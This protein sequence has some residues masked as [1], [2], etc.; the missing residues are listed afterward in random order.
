M[1]KQNKIFLFA[2]AVFLEILISCTKLETLNNI[3]DPSSTNY[4]ATTTSFSRGTNGWNFIATNISVSNLKPYSNK[5]TTNIISFSQ[6]TQ[7]KIYFQEVGIGANDTGY[8]S[9]A[10]IDALFIKDSTNGSIQQIQLPSN[11]FFSPEIIGSTAKL[12]FY[13]GSAYFQ[14]YKITGICWK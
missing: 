8:Y 7:I 3:Y 6:A 12:Y 5:N 1:L 9:H 4:D 14:F 2:V 11:S 13:S 10:D